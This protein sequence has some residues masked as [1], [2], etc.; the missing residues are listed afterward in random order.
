MT[1]NISPTVE[2]GASMN[3]FHE[4]YSV[5]TQKFDIF[6]KVDIELYLG[7]CWTAYCFFY[8]GPIGVNEALI[9]RFSQK[10]LYKNLKI[11]I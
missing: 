5:E 11:S 3:G 2:N 4:Y 8:I 7:L 10:I 9:E 1:I 6:K